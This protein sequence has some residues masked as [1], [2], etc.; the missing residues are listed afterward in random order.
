MSTAT[1]PKFCYYSNT[2]NADSIKK[3]GALYNWYVVS[4]SNPKKIAPAG[5]HVP[6]SAEWDTLGN[7]LIAKGYN[8]DG[9]TDSN[10]IAK[11]LATKTDWATYTSN[12]PTGTIG[13]DLTKNNSSGFSGLPG[14]CRDMMGPFRDQGN[15][16]YW[17]STTVYIM[18]GSLNRYLNFGQVELNGNYYPQSFGFSVRLLR[19]N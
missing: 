18:N 1:A 10:K 13:I 9:T 8:W 5:W 14:G 11:S 12:K 6:S 19:D 2:T 4:P 3:Y 15:Y 16:G 7:Y 17:W